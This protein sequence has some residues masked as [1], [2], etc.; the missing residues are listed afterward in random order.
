MPSKQS[1]SRHLTTLLKPFFLPLGVLGLILVS[2]VVLVMP[3]FQEITDLKSEIAKSEKKLAQLTAKSSY[4]KGL[5]RQELSKRAN[6]LLKVLPS[7]KEVPYLLAIFK[8]FAARNH[9]NFEGISASPGALSQVK[10]QKKD[11]LPLLSFEVSLSGSLA[12]LK[13]FLFLAYK[14]APLLMVESFSLKETDEGAYE[15]KL[16]VESPYLFLPKEIGSVDSPLDEITAEDD[17]TYRRISNL[18]TVQ[19]ITESLDA[20]LPSGRANPFVY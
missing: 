2:A 6:Y 17:L 13:E 5:N 19:A 18:E 16:T 20:T 15:V 10:D 14:T 1:T 7:K 11:A 3:R 4:L 9:L 8:D 12:D